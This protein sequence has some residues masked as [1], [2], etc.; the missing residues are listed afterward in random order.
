[1][2]VFDHSIATIVEQQ[3]L[4]MAI[5]T[6]IV[7]SFGPEGL[8]KIRGS[9]Q[10]LKSIMLSLKQKE[11]LLGGR[12][13][14]KMALNI[15]CSVFVSPAVTPE[16]RKTVGQIIEYLSLSGSIY[17]PCLRRCMARL[18]RFFRE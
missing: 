8:P 2:L 9:V 3:N 4:A 11:H 5:K 12:D 6:S 16:E 17:I 15:Y 14:N 1:M 10:L 13:Q 18:Y 7:D